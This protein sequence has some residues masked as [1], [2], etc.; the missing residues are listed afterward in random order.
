MK[1]LATMR[2]RITELEEQRTALAELL[3]QYIGWGEGQPY[4]A[5]PALLRAAR[6]ACAAAGIYAERFQEYGGRA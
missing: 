3:D 2:A 5:P 4:G 6:K 1:T